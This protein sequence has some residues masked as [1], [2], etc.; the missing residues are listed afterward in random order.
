[1]QF[2]SESEY[3]TAL[4]EIEWLKSIGKL[5]D[6]EFNALSVKYQFPVSFLKAKLRFPHD[7]MIM[8]SDWWAILCSWAAQKRRIH[9]ETQLP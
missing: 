4:Q 5:D 3:R 8:L 2:G 6:A 9:L 1:M 7:Y